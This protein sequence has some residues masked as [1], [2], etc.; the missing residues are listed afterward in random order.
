[1]FS[2]Q[3]LQYRVS[4]G[5]AIGTCLYPHLHE[6]GFYVASR[7]RF[8]KDYIRVRTLPELVQLARQGYKIRMSNR[9]HPNHRAP[10][11]VIPK[12]SRF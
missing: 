5:T 9:T 8:E 1:M 12:I 3:P 10:S 4:R 6:D 7:T 11:L 2:K